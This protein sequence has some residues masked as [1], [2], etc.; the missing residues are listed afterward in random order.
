MAITS[1]SD[2]SVPGNRFYAG[3]TRQEAK[4]LDREK[5]F[6][7]RDFNNLDTNHDDVLSINEIQN[8]RKRVS[9]NYKLDLFLWG[10]AFG[11][12]DVMRGDRGWALIDAV[13]VIAGAIHANKIDK[14][15]KMIDKFVKD[16]NIDPNL[17]CSNAL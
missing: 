12:I 5:S 11:L 6:W 7:R 14:K 2:I 17:P 8:E 3:M 16:N 4:K 9:K 10:G 13:F 15:T 1:L